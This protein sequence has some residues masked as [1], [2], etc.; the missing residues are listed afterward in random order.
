MINDYDNVRGMKKC[1][2]A[3]WKKQEV[4]KGRWMERKM[5]ESI[6]QG[7]WGRSF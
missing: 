2:T 6:L 3:V 5:A 7:K 4:I 1:L